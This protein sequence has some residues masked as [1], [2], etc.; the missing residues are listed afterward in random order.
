M[1]SPQANLLYVKELARRLKEEGSAVEAFALH[2]G[3][4]VRMYNSSKA[5]WAA[6]AGCV[7]LR[8]AK[9]WGARVLR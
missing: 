4:V 2:P 7:E 6:K 1:P 8:K 5:G 9:H 3:G